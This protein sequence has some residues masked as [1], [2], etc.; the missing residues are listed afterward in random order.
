MTKATPIT[1]NDSQAYR[2]LASQGQTALSREALIRIV[3]LCG[4][5]RLASPA[6]NSGHV[7]YFVTTSTMLNYRLTIC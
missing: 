1:A 2:A 3:S 5:Q 4:A 6:P 7:F